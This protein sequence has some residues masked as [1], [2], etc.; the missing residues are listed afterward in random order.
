[1][2]LQIGSW[3]QAIGMGWLVLHDLGGSATSLGIVALVRGASLVLLSP[4]GGYLADRLERRRQLV[5][6]TSTSATI[7]A[8]LAIL[9]TTDSITL[10]M[11][12]LAATG[13]G[14]VEALAGPIRMSL[15]YHS[16][17]GE[18]LTNAVALNALGGNAMRVI[19]PAIGGALIG[20]VGTQGAFQLQAAC[21]ALSAFLTWRLAPNTP[22]HIEDR[23]GLFRSIAGGLRYVVRDRRML[24]IVVM[25]LIPSIIVYPYVT[26][27]P[28]F[29]R[30]VLHSD[31]SAY[32]Y[33]AAAVGV[34]SLAGGAAVAVFAGRGKTGQFM[35]WTCLAYSAAIGAFALSQHLLLSI[36]ILAV[37][38]VFH[39]IYSALNSSLMQLK[40]DEEY[41]G[42]VMS[43]QTMM[44]GTTPFAALMMGRMIDDWGAQHVVGAWMAVA[45]VITLVVA[46]FSNELRK[47]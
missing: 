10:W 7:A 41:R 24:V 22:E 17:A 11:V 3:V 23:P 33:L 29:A 1:M 28:V 27:L 19:G 30:D 46:L 4:V 26:F 13:A 40:A 8:I 5:I 9:I 18:D 35:V 6:Y 34:G 21:L 25:A 31:Q 15:V 14:L 20:T 2:A 16:V 45:V 38:G 42:Q 36:G 39:S 37:A 44:W 47:V 32:G 12:Y 43:L